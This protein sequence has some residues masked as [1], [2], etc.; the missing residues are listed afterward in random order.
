MTLRIFMK[1]SPLM[2]SGLQQSYVRTGVLDIH[3]MSNRFRKA[4]FYYNKIS[5]GFPVPTSDSPE[6]IKGLHM[7]KLTQETP[8]Q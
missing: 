3:V 1:T 8:E 4:Y 2:P 7:R 6:I 5:F